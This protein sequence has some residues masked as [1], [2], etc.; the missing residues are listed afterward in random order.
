[1]IPIPKIIAGNEVDVV[2]VVIEGHSNGR[3]DMNVAIGRDVIVNCRGEKSATKWMSR[4]TIQEI[5]RM[6]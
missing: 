2:V 6:E 3:L 5:R 1:M 4:R